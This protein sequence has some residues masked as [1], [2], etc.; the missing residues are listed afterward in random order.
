MLGSVKRSV[1]QAQ[2]KEGEK[3]MTGKGTYKTKQRALLCA[4]LKTVGQAHVTVND[5][6]EYFRGQG[7]QMGTATIYRQLERMVDEGLVNKYNIDAGS[8][9]CFEYLGERPVC[10]DTVCF[11]CKCEK[12][13]RLI[14]LHCDV[15]KGLKQHVEAEHGFVI[16]P[17]RTVFYGVCEE[18]RKSAS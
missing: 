2:T 1:W 14:H 5:V 16:D 4:Y 18:C 10:P 9:A 6:Y 3:R 8:P 11:H 15:I 7:V 12:C 13:G 17:R